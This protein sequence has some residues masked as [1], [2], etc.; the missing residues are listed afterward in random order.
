MIKRVNDS[1]CPLCKQSNRCDVKSN[2]GCWCMNTKVPAA[3]LAQVPV[4]FKAKTCICNSCIEHYNQQQTSK[5]VRKE[6]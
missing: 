3:L 4:E 6:E 2:K 1:I 5:I